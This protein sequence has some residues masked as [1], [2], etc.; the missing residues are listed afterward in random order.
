MNK[1]K[2]K[3]EFSNNTQQREK[4]T[5]INKSQMAKKNKSSLGNAFLGA[6][7]LFLVLGPAT[8]LLFLINTPLHIKLGL[9][10]KTVL[11]P[12]LGWF[13]ADETAIAWADQTYL[14]AGVAFVVGA[15]RRQSWCIPL[16]FYTC[17]AASFILLVARIRWPLL[18]ANGFGVLTDAEQ[19]S[20]FYMY[21]YAYILWGWYGM[22]YLWS[23]RAVYDDSKGKFD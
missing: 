15:L 10:E 18:E 6:F 12:E 8:Q 17:A 3:Q 7:C 23:N 2:T 16:G 11:D 19:K 4:S 14:V 5:A 9:S 21:S 20:F 22:Y 1:V 13:L